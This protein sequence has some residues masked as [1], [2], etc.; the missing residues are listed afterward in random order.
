MGNA[1]IRNNY[2]HYAFPRWNNNYFNNYTLLSEKFEFSEK[3]SC[4]VK[5]KKIF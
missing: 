2:F 3:I 5:F 4:K 1:I